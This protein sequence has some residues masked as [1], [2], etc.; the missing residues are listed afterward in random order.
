MS[1]V[2]GQ[3]LKCAVLEQTVAN[4]WSA[5]PHDDDFMDIHMSEMGGDVRGS[6]TLRCWYI[7]WMGLLFSNFTYGLPLGRVWLGGTGE[8]ED[9]GD[10]IE[11]GSRARK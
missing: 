3:S 7:L 1:A 10:D 8:R 6:L 9:I 11:D 5:P 4:Y 2:F